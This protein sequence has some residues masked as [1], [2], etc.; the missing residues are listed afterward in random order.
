MAAGYSR[1]HISPAP[2]AW[3]SEQ[4]RRQ[5]ILENKSNMFSQKLSDISSKRNVVCAELGVPGWGGGSAGVQVLFSF[6]GRTGG[7]ANA[8]LSSGQIYR[9][10][11]T[12]PSSWPLPAGGSGQTSRKTWGALSCRSAYDDLASG[13]DSSWVRPCVHSGKWQWLVQGSAKVT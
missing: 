12:F 8:L 7:M 6:L 11:S 5:K 2:P 13:I 1:E 9:Q 4:M 3:S 10:C